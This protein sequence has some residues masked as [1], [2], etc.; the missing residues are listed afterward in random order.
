MDVNYINPFINASMN[1]FSTFAGLES[2]PGRPAVRTRPLADKGVNGF[3]SLNGH[4]ISG[5]FIINFSSGFLKE[6]LSVIFDHPKASMEEICDLAGELT[7]MITGSAKAELSKNGFFFDVAVPGISHTTP[8]IP[9]TLK[10]NPIIVVPFDTTAGKFH[11]EAS[12]QRIEEDFQQDTM[13]EV[14]PPGGYVSVDTFAKETR[15]D[16]IK[17]RRLL[18]TG[19]LT[20]KKISNRQW[21]IPESEFGKIQ[22]YRPPKARRPE[23]VPQ[24]LMDETVSV[25]EFSKITGVSPVKIKKFLRTGFL[26]GVQ[27]ADRKWRVVRGQVSKFKKHG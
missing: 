22:G 5:Y 26:K 4:G 27:D 13:P 14:K 9:G 18:K 2:R 20:G 8:E 23:S 3:I 1:V 19:F 24:S 21:H 11:I 15:M 17:V 16:P 10:N 7:N 25:E 6:I 12:I